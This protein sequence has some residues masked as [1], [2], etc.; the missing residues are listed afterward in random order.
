MQNSQAKKFT[1]AKIVEALCIKYDFLRNGKP[2]KGKLAEFLGVSP[3]TI[4]T[5]MS[6]DSL[7]KDLIFRK[8][9]GIN[10]E[11]LETGEGEMFSEKNEDPPWMQVALDMKL[12]ERYV[13]DLYRKIPKEA[14]D[15]VL[16]LLIKS[17]PED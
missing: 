5:W 6:R 13:L 1:S 9:K 2:A 3:S 14:R 17:L 8:C 7:D 12:Q 10:F 4:S 15:E 11:W 16:R